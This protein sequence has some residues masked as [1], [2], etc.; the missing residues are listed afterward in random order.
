MKKPAFVCLI[1]VA[2]ILFCFERP[3]YWSKIARF[4]LIWSLGDDSASWR[5]GRRFPAED[6]EEEATSS[7][8]SRCRPFEPSD[9]LRSMGNFSRISFSFEHFSVESRPTIVLSTRLFFDVWNVWWENDFWR[10]PDTSWGFIL[11]MSTWE[12]EAWWCWRCGGLQFESYS[13]MHATAPF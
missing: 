9:I 12:Y 2:Y 10:L 11:S 1:G 3:P 6:W 7:L 8:P 4:R 5:S 13:R